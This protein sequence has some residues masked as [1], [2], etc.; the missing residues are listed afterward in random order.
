MPVPCSPWPK[1]IFPTLRVP[2]VIVWLAA[3][4][5]KMAESPAVQDATGA[6]VVPLS[7]LPPESQFK[8]VVVALSLALLTVVA[9]PSHH[10]GAAWE[11]HSD[12]AKLV[13]MN[14][15][16]REGLKSRDFMGLERKKLDKGKPSFHS[17]MSGHLE[18][19]STLL[20]RK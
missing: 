4:P 10:S 18:I 8:P 6:D 20:R 16:E 1:V 2:A 19:T 15:A 7:Q 12:K 11:K 9:L 13:A 14:A 5:P 3:V 17:N